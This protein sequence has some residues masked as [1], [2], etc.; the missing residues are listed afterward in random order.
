MSYVVLARRWRPQLFEDVVGQE[1]ITRTLTKAIQ[2]NRIGH[3]YLFT[4]P[5]GIGKTTTARIF[6]KAL[7]C[8][9]GL[10][11]KPCNK[12]ASC[13]EISQGASID[14]LEIDG[15][16]NR[17]IDEIR[18]LR[19]NVKFAPARDRFKIY[20]IDEVHML[21]NEAFNALLKTLEEP[22]EHVKFI[23]ATTSPHKIP[24]TIISRC[25]RFDFRRITITDIAKRLKE[26]SVSEKVKVSEEAAFAIARNA[27][28]SMRDGESIL[29]QLI[30]FCEGEIKT[31]DLNTLLGIVDQETFQNL[32]NTV[33]ENDT[34]SALKLI[35]RII[36]EGKDIGQFI[37][38]W[39]Q[40]WRDLLMAKVGTTQLI[41]LPE[42]FLKKITKQAEHFSKEDLFR[43][44]G[45]LTKTQDLTRKSVS[46]R[47]P[48]EI[49]V[50]ELTH[51]SSS[52]SPHKYNST[53]SLPLQKPAS[54]PASSVSQKPELSTPESAA[55][56]LIEPAP[57]EPA[58]ASSETS[59]SSAV[60]LEEV[61]AKWQV[62]LENVKKE[63]LV[64][65]AFLMEGEP[66]KVGDRKIT[67]AFDKDFSFHRV[68]CERTENKKVI[69]KA[70][71]QIFQHKFRLHC[72][73]HQTP[74]E[75][76]AKS[77]PLEERQKEEIT[78][79]VMK[80]PIVKKTMQVFN[81]GI[82]DIKEEEP[83]K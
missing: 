40:Y 35:D 60:S 30:S 73:E 71:E 29:D 46:S 62:V 76:K 43:I 80:D 6:A 55:S 63:R 81:V 22:P 24:L 75:K 8:H 70:M 33:I 41:E 59:Q 42:S 50:V 38:S 21:T 47:I 26:I 34:V 49:A 69:E 45:I 64:A 66:V 2:T 57:A 83:S 14:V 61:I 52:D 23:F 12:C 20:I 3:A 78:E 11:P 17:G 77:K 1:H 82:T 44:I 28:G 18:E 67:V 51:A 53:P 10:G 7:N 72:I 74:G 19:S 65:S 68:S 31:E 13:K 54:P 58:P 4:G 79:K 56:T 37:K 36:N 48:L 25:Q 32:G 9:K 39:Q 27:S 5:R 15:A 16:S